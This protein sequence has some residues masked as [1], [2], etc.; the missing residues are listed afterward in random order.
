MKRT[1][2]ALDQHS[3]RSRRRGEPLD[4]A[5]DLCEGTRDVCREMAC[6]R[7]AYARVDD[8]PLNGTW[9]LRDHVANAR[10][11]LD[12]LASALA[13]DVPV[14]GLE[15][16]IARSLLERVQILVSLC[17]HRRDQARHG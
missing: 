16:D 12:R 2:D 6:F 14:V 15:V 17:E 4:A 7:A 9:S 11:R 1:G 8:T 5:V 3:F 13:L 10:M